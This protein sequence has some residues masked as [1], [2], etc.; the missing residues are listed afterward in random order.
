M[1]NII[2]GLGNQMFQYAFAYSISKKTNQAFELDITD[3][4]TYWHPYKLDAY[5]HLYQ[6]NAFQIEGNF[7][8]RR[9]KLKKINLLNKV[10]GRLK[11]IKRKLLTK[12]YY[13]ELHHNFDKNVFN[14]QGNTYFVG[15][16][17]SER[18]FKEYRG[19]L[20]KQFMLKSPLQ[21][22]S[23]KYKKEILSSNAVS[24]HVRRGDY[25]ENESINAF[26]GTCPLRYYQ[27]SV[28]R[29][30]QSISEAYFY[31]FSDDLTWAED[32]FDFIKNKI[33]VKLSKDVP[34]CEEMHLMSLC[35]HNIIANSSFSWW[36][37]WL[38]NNPEKIVIAPK[39]WFS[40]E[41]MNK[42]AK[43]IVCDSWVKI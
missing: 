4:N 8:S 43:D 33:F 22:Q 12:G 23:Q 27:K 5:W 15:Y 38:N 13:Q 19:E 42:Q 7:T 2:G 28:K 40:D 9:I 31:I 18:Y 24:L 3:F 10:I 1:V 29:I 6:L 25:V 16:W 26:H 37:A 30:T 41:K 32:N 36:G 14:I 34:D 17:Q 35:R 39:K 20:L 11:I 21:A